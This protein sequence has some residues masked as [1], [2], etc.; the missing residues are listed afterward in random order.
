MTN[1]ADDR[2]LAAIL[3]RYDPGRLDLQSEL[4]GA[5]RRAG[6]TPIQALKALRSHYKIGLGDANRLL[7]SHPAW[8][9]AA[10]EHDHWTDAMEE[11]F[12]TLDAEDEL[13][14]RSSLARTAPQ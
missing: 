3:R 2:Q 9:D 6:C 10:R 14:A 7:L 4:M 11:A 12:T 8:A 1:P 5:L 13:T